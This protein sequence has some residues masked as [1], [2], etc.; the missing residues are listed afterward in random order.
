MKRSN[1]ILL[2]TILILGA[3]LS[4]CAGGA[5]AASSWPGL[6]ADENTA[7]LAFNQHVYAVNIANGAEKWRFPAEA[8]NKITFYA[9]PTL[10]QDGQLLVGGF[11]HVLYSLD[12]A[13]GG[14]KWA[15]NGAANRYIG[16]PM[17]SEEG[18]FAPNADETLYAL[19][20]TGKPLWSFKTGGANWARPEGDTECNCLFLP[21]MDHRLYAVDADTGSLKWKTDDLGG[22]LVGTP[23]HSAENV[24]YV[25][26][27]NSEMLA[28][29]A[30]SGKTI[31]RTPTTGWAWAGP[32]LKDDRLYFGD[33]S[34]AFYGLDAGD[35]T[36]VWEIQS[37]GAIS[38]TPLVTDDTIY[39]TTEAG[40]LYAVDFNGETKWTKPVGGKLYTTPVLAGDTLIVAPVGADSTLVALDLSGNQKWAFTPEK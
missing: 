15:Y 12:P 27:F 33:L 30:E 31:W 40:S 28:L 17:I 8:D 6:S 10:T 4:A 18:I 36:K 3:A 2:F 5:G 19:D 38:E 26:T 34:G 37:D 11:D 39:F 22:S 32:G 25:G 1:L 13:T 29:D 14:Q 9:T 24:L 7:Y 23:A 16:G 21:S 35:G 20:M